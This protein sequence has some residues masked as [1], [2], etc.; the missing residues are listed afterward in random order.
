V[1]PVGRRTGR[2]GRVEHEVEHEQDVL[3]LAVPDRAG[4]LE[5]EALQEAD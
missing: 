5:A 2:L 1:E 3:V 4:R